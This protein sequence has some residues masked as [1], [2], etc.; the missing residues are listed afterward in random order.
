MAVGRG[1][2]RRRPGE[3]RDAIIQALTGRKSAAKVSEIQEAVTKLIGPVAP[4]SVRSYL[5]IGERQGLFVREGFG[6]YRLTR[7]SR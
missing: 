3:I 1:G 2:G 7:K 4:S 6:R 5:Q